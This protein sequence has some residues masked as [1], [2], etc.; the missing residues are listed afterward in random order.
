MSP[1]QIRGLLLEEAVLHLLRK[2]G[3]KTIDI[4]GADPTLGT[5]GAGIFVRGRGG[6]HQIDAIADF[7]IHQP[8]SNPNRLLVEAKCFFRRDVRLPELRNA[9]GVLKD[10]SEHWVP[11]PGPIARPAA[12]SLSVRD[13]FRIRLFD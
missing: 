9:V 6:K 10:V 1:A 3:Y 11:A 5:C 8:F 4:P 7:L 12:V 13:G 2:S